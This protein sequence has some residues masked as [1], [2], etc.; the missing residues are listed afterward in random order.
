VRC[1]AVALTA[2]LIGAA[3]LIDPV[4]VPRA[5]AQHAQPAPV[6]V[7]P[8]RFIVILA[9]GFTQ[10]SDEYASALNGEAGIDIDLTYNTAFSG[11]AGTFSTAAIEKLMTDPAVAEVDPDFRVHAEGQSLEPNIDR[12][13]ADQSDAISGDGHGDVDVDVAVIDSGVGPNEDLNIAGGYNCMGDGY[14]RDYYG[15]GTHV[16]GIIGARDNGFGVVGMAPGARIWQ[17]RVLDH[18]GGGTWSQIICG[19]DWVAG[20]AGIIEVANM[21]LGAGMPENGNGCDSSPAHRAICAMTN[22]GVTVVAAACNAN[23][24]AGT[25][26]P[27]KYPEVISVSAFAEWDGKPGGQAGCRTTPDG[28]YGCDD[29][30]ASF[31]NYG[32][33]VDI[34]APGVGVRSTLFDNRYGYWSGTSMATPHVT[35]AAAL[36]RARYGPMS[37]AAVRER[38]LLIAMSG[39]VPGDPDAYPEP[40]L[41]V[42]SLGPGSITHL[43]SV[44]NGDRVTIRTSNL[45]P[46]TRAIFRLDGVFV[47]GATVDSD[48]A[49]HRTVAIGGLAYGGHRISV[50]NNR[51]SLSDTFLVRPAVTVSTSSVIVGQAV[52]VALTGYTAGSSVLVSLDTGNGARPLTRVR[53]DDSGAG[54][55]IVVI[56][57]AAGGSRRVTAL[58]STGVSTYTHVSIRPTL[59]A[60]SPVVAGAWDP[61]VLRGFHSGELVDLRWGSQ[62]GTFLRSK[63]TTA[64]GSGDLNIQIPAATVPGKH[65]LWAVGASGTALRITVNTTGQASDPTPSPTPTAIETAT[66]IGPSPTATET[67]TSAAT[68]TATETQTPLATG[69]TRP[70]ATETLPPIESATVPVPEP[71]IDGSPTSN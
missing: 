56:P 57:T 1:C 71:T 14:L 43:Q 10:S 42:A 31:S 24:D 26:T 45:I 54:S 51:K 9:G 46:G 48:G 2:L 47:G 16:A 68:S 38:L 6:E 29:Q 30:R 37:P 20:H 70:T 41:N 12:V 49:A 64:T 40:I 62:T 52:T 7:V 34:A 67:A 28:F 27:G 5:D 65:S 13:D 19:M 23:M 39:P 66:E 36:L 21:S 4:S 60:G 33:T 53:V 15:H 63:V 55:S 58:D 32:P 69:T 18:Y 3:G 17:V 35:G 25:C 59:W 11:F 50:R 44:R 61:V 22:A 8:G